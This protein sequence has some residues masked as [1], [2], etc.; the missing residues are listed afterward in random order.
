MPTVVVV[1]VIIVV[2]VVVVVVVI[3][4]V[5][6]LVFCSW[7][8]WRTITSSIFNQ[9]CWKLAQKREEKQLATFVR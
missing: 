8:L 9:F 4:V 3:V 1:V 6:F 2:I 7:Y 5:V